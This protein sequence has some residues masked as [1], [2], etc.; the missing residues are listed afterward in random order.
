MRIA[1]GNFHAAL[2]RKRITNKE[3]ILLLTDMAESYYETEE[4]EVV[5][6]VFQAELNEVE[7]FLKLQVEEGRSCNETTLSP[8]DAIKNYL[9]LVS[10]ETGTGRSS[11]A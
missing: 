8:D 10:D 4:E 7:E 11:L 2:K 6:G 5:A 3:S 1:K 9:D